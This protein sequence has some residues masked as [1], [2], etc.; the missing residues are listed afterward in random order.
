M[1][2]KCFANLS[3]MGPNV[4]Y[5]LTTLG[6][7]IKYHDETILFSSGTSRLR[8]YETLDTALEVM[9]DKF[10]GELKDLPLTAKFE[11]KEQKP[12]SLSI[13]F[14]TQIGYKDERAKTALKRWPLRRVS[15]VPTQ[16]V[17]TDI[18]EKIKYFEDLAV[19]SKK[20]KRYTESQEEIV[21]EDGRIDAR[22]VALLGPGSGYDKLLGGQPGKC[23]D[24]IVIT[25]YG[26]TV[27]EAEIIDQ[28]RGAVDKLGRK[29]SKQMQDVKGSPLFATDNYAKIGKGMETFLTA[30]RLVKERPR[31]IKIAI[32]AELMDQIDI[33]LPPEQLIAKLLTLGSGL[34][35]DMRRVEDD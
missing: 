30:S 7:A 24:D 17:K 22:F 20:V 4:Y 31:A 18:S 23:K 15:L 32:P 11:T 13:E 8:L 28:T 12:E 35:L 5:T 34:G 19:Y 29:V 16:K 10:Q 2:K 9:P 33:N 26:I 25:E 3:I 6:E 1:F 14:L 21:M 27:E